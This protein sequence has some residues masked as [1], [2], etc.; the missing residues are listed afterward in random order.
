MQ[1]GIVDRGLELSRAQDASRTFQRT[2]NERSR[3]RPG[4]AAAPSPVIDFISVWPEQILERDRDINPSRR[5]RHRLHR[6]RS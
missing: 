1:D 4:L 6:E 2:K 3:E 5:S